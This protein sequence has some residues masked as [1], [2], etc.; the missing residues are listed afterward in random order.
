M[1]PSVPSVSAWGSPLINASDM[2]IVQRIM[3]NFACAC[4]LPLQRIALCQ[5]KGFLVSSFFCVARLDGVPALLLL[6][7]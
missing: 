1:L 4:V 2:G 5:Q 3:L 6:W 7:K